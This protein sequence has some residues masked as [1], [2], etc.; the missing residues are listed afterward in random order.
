[1]NLSYH[2]VI[3][4]IL[5][6]GK[7]INTVSIDDHNDWYDHSQHLDHTQQKAIC[8]N[9]AAAQSVVDAIL[10]SGCAANE[11][12]GQHNNHANHGDWEQH[13]DSKS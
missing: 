6:E 5:I 2:P 10:L 4:S 12:T 13:I 3:D 9:I 11:E 7:K 8:I 1:M